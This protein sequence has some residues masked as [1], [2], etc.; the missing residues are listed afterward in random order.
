[1]TIQELKHS[2]Y[3]K[4]LKKHKTKIKASKELG[5]SYETLKRYEK[6]KRSRSI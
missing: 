5:V 1:M 3:E 2:L 6:Q 4:A